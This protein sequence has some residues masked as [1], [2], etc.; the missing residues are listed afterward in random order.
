MSPPAVEAD[1]VLY[2]RGDKMFSKAIPFLAAGHRARARSTQSSRTHDD[3]IGPSPSAS[4]KKKSR[5][6]RD[7][8]KI[9]ARTEAERA[10]ESSNLDSAVCSVPRV[11]RAIH[12]LKF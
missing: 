12:A 1:K 8:K 6:D 2:P 9:G 7:R 5:S 10:D 3:A 4:S 11:D